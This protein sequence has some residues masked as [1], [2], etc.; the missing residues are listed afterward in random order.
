MK[1]KEQTI[2]QIST[3]KNTT[4][5]TD[6]FTHGNNEN[7]VNHGTSEPREEVNNS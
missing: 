5:P 4:S 6:K 2:L 3:S 7:T 1:K